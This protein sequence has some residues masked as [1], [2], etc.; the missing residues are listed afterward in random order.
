MSTNQRVRDKLPPN[1][2]VLDNESYD[3]SIIG[4]T[5]EGAAIYSYD[6][7]IEEY[8]KDNGCTEEEA[9]DWI[10]YNTIRAIPY[11]PNPKPKIVYEGV[12]L[13]WRYYSLM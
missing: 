10:E 13:L 9:V 11:M 2:I 1:S 8:M 12:M 4:M 7:M 5:F 3:N 6:K